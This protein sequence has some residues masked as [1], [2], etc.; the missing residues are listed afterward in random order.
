M[1]WVAAV[2]ML[3]A[4]APLPPPRAVVS[5]QRGGAPARTTALV[6]PT[7]CI[8]AEPLLCT[9]APYSKD[10]GPGT[11]LPVDAMIDP[12]VHLKLELAGYTLADARTL[13]LVSADRTDTTDDSAVSTHVEN[14]PTVAELSDGDRLAAA[15][16]L[17]LGAVL[18]STVRVG[19]D[20]GFGLGE[21]VRFELVLELVSVPD[22]APIWTVRCSERNEVPEIT[23]RTL[24][25]CAGDGV[26]AWR[27]P[28]AVIGRQP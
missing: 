11:P 21:P 15:G 6:M 3:A 12:I 24:A 5:V 17:G 13:R 28:D 10:A 26:L 9:Q 7:T 2:V 22:A 27:A 19:R 25:S 4:C 20:G 16:S 14:V 8:A 23:L 18:R 1:K